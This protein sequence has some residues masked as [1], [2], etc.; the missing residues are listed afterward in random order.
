MNNKLTRRRLMQILTYNPK[1]GLFTRNITISSRAKKG[2][3]IGNKANHICGYIQI[4]IDSC[5]YLAHRLAVLYMTGKLPEYETDHINGNKADNR[6]ENLR[7][8]T[9]EI[10]SQNRRKAQSNNKSGLLGAWFDKRTSKWKSQIKC[11]KKRITVGTF[12]TAID[13]HKAYLNAKRKYHEGC[14]I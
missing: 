2:M 12:D 10:N 9:V 13:A 11:G 14:T 7:S 3:I 5:P 1:T 4:S 6:W 8:V